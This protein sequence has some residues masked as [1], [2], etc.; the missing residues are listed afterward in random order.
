LA[1]REGIANEEQLRRVQ[2]RDKTKQAHF[3]VAAYC[4]VNETLDPEHYNLFIPDL[5]KTGWKASQHSSDVLAERTADKVEARRQQA[6]AIGLGQL[7]LLPSNVSEIVD[8]LLPK[9][10]SL[11]ATNMLYVGVCRYDEGPNFD[12]EVVRWAALDGGCLPAITARD[13]TVIKCKK[14][15]CRI[16]LEAQGFRMEA[17]WRS[18]LYCNVRSVETGLHV[19]LTASPNRLWRCNGTGSY[20]N[21]PEQIKTQLD[22]QWVCCVFVAYAPVSLQQNFDFAPSLPLFADR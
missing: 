2:L 4:R 10:A 15:G 16:K 18:M 21:R 17:I 11:L 3:D 1:V 9:V 14:P 12:R 8:E 5:Y 22:E 7:M 19:A 20:R 6:L 13:G